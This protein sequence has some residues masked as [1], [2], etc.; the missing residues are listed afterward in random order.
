M[1]NSSDPPNSWYTSD[2][3]EPHPSIPNRW[4]FVGRK[5]DRISL[6]TGEKVLPL[7]IEGRIKSHPYVRE[8]V[9][10]GIDRE[11]PGVLLFRALGAAARLTDEAFLDEVWPVIERANCEAEGFSRITR[12]MVAIAGEGTECPLTDKSSIKRG[13]VYRDFAGAIDAT[14]AA[15][16]SAKDTTSLLV[17]DVPQL[18]KWILRTVGQIL[19]KPIDAVVDFF[20]S[21]MDSLKAL[22]LRGLILGNIDLGGRVHECTSMIAYDCGNAERLAQKLWAIRLGQDLDDGRS[23]TRLIDSYVDKYSE[24]FRSNK[25]VQM[26]NNK[27]ATVVS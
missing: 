2:L 8:A 20:S 12:E 9:I 4:K 7:P 11:V 24:T 19:G 16:N 10:F 14:Y 22:Q 23:M 1:T 18:E 5:D 26:T 21:G 27:E 13:L 15:A 6:I 25:P 17:L 3:F